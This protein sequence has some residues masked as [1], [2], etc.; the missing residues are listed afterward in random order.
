M[1]NNQ[2][3]LIRDILY[4]AKRY[5]LPSDDLTTKPIGFDK[6][7]NS[8][9]KISEQNSATFELKDLWYLS[10][11]GYIKIE[12][13]PN[14]IFVYLTKK[15]SDS[16]ER[17][18]FDYVIFCKEMIK[19]KD[20]CYMSKECFAKLVELENCANLNKSNIWVVQC[21]FLDQMIVFDAQNKTIKEHMKDIVKSKD[22]KKGEALWEKLRLK[23]IR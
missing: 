8:K 15:G 5:A 21:N 22:N 13:M 16:V 4:V 9:I 17:L 12:D 7:E 14:K 1:N 20:D 19:P 10:D 6:L 23:S 11:G 2:E 3:R 18:G